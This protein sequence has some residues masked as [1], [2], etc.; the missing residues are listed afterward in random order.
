M[1]INSIEFVIVTCSHIKV[2]KTA[3]IRKS[4]KFN[5]AVKKVKVNTGFSFDLN[6]MA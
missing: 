1:L 4:E 5:L 3:K 2:R 6:M